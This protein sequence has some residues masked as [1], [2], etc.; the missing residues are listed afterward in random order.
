MS[1]FVDVK[2]NLT[3]LKCV[4]KALERLGFKGKLEMHDKPQ[5]LFGY[6]GDKRKQKAHLIIRRKYVGDSS[7]DIG[8]EKQSNGM[9]AAHI[10]EFDQGTGSY[11]GRKA[12]Y[13]TQWQQK[14][15]TFYAVE[16][17][18]DEYTRRGIKWTEDVDEKDRPRVRAFI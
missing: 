6:H 16:K 18:E 12:K 1:H 3:D 8:F 2:T 9:I 14:L 10:S 4:A 17:A 5:N 7:N 15:F 11:A 13:G